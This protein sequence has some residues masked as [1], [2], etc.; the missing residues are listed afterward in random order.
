MHGVNIISS[1][2]VSKNY[3]KV[4]ASEQTGD[5]LIISWY[6]SPTIGSSYFT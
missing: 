2:V 4:S 1:G 5:P 6:L 3:R